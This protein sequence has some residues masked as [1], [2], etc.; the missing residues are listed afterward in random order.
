[1]HKRTTAEAAAKARAAFAASFPNEAARSAFYR[2]IAA[3][4]VAARRERENSRNAEIKQLRQ[5]LETL[6]GKTFGIGA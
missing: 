5:A 1:M 6:T 3:R 2:D 4:S